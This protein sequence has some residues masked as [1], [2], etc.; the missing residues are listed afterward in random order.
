MGMTVSNNE[1]QKLNVH[2]EN[3]GSLST[4]NEMRTSLFGPSRLILRIYR[5]LMSFVVHCMSTSSTAVL[6]FLLLFWYYGGV[7]L[8]L[9]LFIAVLGELLLL[10]LKVKVKKTNLYSE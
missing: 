7:L 6:I 9:A 2:V 8:L 3:T 1:E 4:T 5:K 10:N